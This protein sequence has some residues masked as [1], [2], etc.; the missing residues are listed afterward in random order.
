LNNFIVDCCLATVT[1]A[2]IEKRIIAAVSC[3]IFLQEFARR[4]YWN[5][6]EKLENKESKLRKTAI[7]TSSSPITQKSILY[8]DAF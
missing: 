5:K 1:G 8:G 7:V 4:V 3:K 6:N 2:N